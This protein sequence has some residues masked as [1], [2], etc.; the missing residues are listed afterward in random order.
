MIKNKGSF[1]TR[2]TAFVI[3]AALIAASLFIFT[4]GNYTVSADATVTG[5]QQ[6][7]SSIQAKQTELK[8]E[9]EAAKAKKQ[10]ALETKSYYDNLVSATQT[11]IDLTVQLLDELAAGITEKQERIAVLNEDINRKWAEL[12]ENIKATYQSERVTY[13]EMIFNSESFQDFLNN[14]DRAGV[15]LDYRNNL[16]KAINEEL[17]QVKQEKADMEQQREEQKKLKESLEAKKA[18][19]KIHQDEA[20]A[21]Y[22]EA[23]ATEEGY[24]ALV[25]ENEAA[26]ADLQA[27]INARLAQIR[28]EEEARLAA[29]GT[30]QPSDGSAANTVYNSDFRWPLDNSWSYISCPFGGGHR[31]IDIPASTGSNV[32]ACQGGEV[33]VSEYHYSW[34]NYVL[35]SHGNGL[36]TLYAHNSVLCVVPGQTVTKGQVIAKVG[37]TGNSTGPHCHFEVWVSYNASNYVNPLGYVNSSST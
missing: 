14:I 20:T 18:E 3:S 21:Y 6:E 2:V 1:L 32:Y 36:F 9:L 30:Y 24:E 27:S 15:M 19:L 35:I 11:E 34:G 17:A 5:L 10:S 25:A 22:V 4:P 13:L 29:A 12:R 26:M 8:A 7:L 31:G 33:V 16:V 28:A 23:S 37:S